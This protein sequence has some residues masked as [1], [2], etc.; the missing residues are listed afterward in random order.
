MNYTTV[1]HVRPHTFGHGAH[2]FPPPRSLSP[3]FFVLF[4][5]LDAG[6][7]LLTAAPGGVSSLLQIAGLWFNG[8]TVPLYRRLPLF[9]LQIKS[10]KENTTAEKEGGGL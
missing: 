10:V 5:R 3:L 4:L 6:S 1:T 8:R 2:L 9:W 7:F